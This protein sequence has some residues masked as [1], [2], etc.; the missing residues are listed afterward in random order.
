MSHDRFTVAHRRPERQPRLHC[1]ITALAVPGFNAQRRPERQPRLHVA[2][3]TRRATDRARSTK[4]GASTPA[5]RRPLRDPDPWCDSLNEG[6]SVNPGYTTPNT[7]ALSR[8]VYRSTKAGASTPATPERTSPVPKA[9]SSAQRRPERQPRLHL[10][11]RITPPAAPYAQR[12]PERQPRLHL[13]FLEK[14][15][16]TLC[17]QRRPE[18]QPRLHAQDCG[19]PDHVAAPLNEGRSVNPGYTRNSRARRPDSTST[20]NEG[21]SVNPGYT[22]LALFLSCAMR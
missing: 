18:R 10:A 3:P 16:A 8:R 13:F 19:R 15:S 1:H 2:G 22:C 4:A 14:E 5:T 9:L 17:A 12:R 7:V 21:R 6:R 20:L 11:V